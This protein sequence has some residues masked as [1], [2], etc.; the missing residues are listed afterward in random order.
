MGSDVQRKGEIE[1]PSTWDRCE[2]SG[3]IQDVR[4][5][6]PVFTQGSY[7]GLF[8]VT[9]PEDVGEGQ[10]VSIIIQRLSNGNGKKPL[11]N[12]FRAVITDIAQRTDMQV[13]FF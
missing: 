8:Q 10:T 1:L 3:T 7:Y 13:A 9:L 6:K 11:P 4:A 2:I 5:L 12:N